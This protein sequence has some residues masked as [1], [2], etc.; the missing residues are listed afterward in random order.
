MYKNW[1][2]WRLDFKADQIDVE[3]IRSLLIKETLI[4][5]KTDNKG[6]L[7]VVIRPRFHD[8]GAQELEDLIRYGIFIIETAS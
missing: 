2:E 5:H 7:C 4:I 3:S 6:R 1:V 8:P